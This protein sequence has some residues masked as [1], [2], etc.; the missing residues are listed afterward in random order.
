MS[1]L[2]V[3]FSGMGPVGLIF[4]LSRYLFS[5]CTYSGDRRVL[6]SGRPPCSGSLGAWC[7]GRL[8]GWDPGSP[9]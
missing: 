4:L 8:L 2:W 9:V 1:L 7:G 6:W 3:P 5:C